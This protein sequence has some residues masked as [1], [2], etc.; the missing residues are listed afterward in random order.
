MRP[1]SLLAAANGHAAVALRDDVRARAENRPAVYRMLGNEGEVVYVGKSVSVRN[2]LLSYFRADRG[3]KAT[4]II[5]ATRRIEWEYVPSEFAALLE[6]LHAIQRFKPIFNVQH[7]L[8]RGFCFIKLTRDEAPR[9]MMVRQVLSDG[10]VYYGPFRGLGMVRELVREVADTLEL[11]DCPPSVR[12][13][14]ADQIDL[15][16]ADYTPRC[17]RADLNRCLG[18]CAGRCT[19]TEYDTRVTEARRFLEGDVHRPLNVLQDRMREAAARLQFEYAAN[20]RDRAQRLEAAREELVALRRTV[21][22]LTFVYPVRG[23]AGDD[24][25]YLIR[26]GR[27]R[28]EYAWPKN[29]VERNRL[30]QHAR[31][32][33]ARREQGP[34]PID[35][36]NVREVLLIARWF[37]L[38]PHEL[39]SVITPD[40]LPRSNDAEAANLAV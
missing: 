29:E 38:K 13:R 21:E 23:H 7:K 15:F 25:V 33:F 4:D 34:A 2:R 18:P 8:D 14:W 24:R 31:A 22:S 1:G 9:L 32:T 19:R 12:L 27:I 40:R 30:L 6:E 39:D 3:E 5:S 20:L 16:N 37:R 35:A 36:D 11:R 17:M 26:R 28:A 10:A